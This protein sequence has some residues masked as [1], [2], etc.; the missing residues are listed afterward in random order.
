[1]APYHIRQYQERDHKQ[2]LNVFS[3]GMEEN[4]LTALHHALMLPRTPPDLPWGA[5]C[6]GPSVWFL[7]AGHYEH[8]PSVPITVA[9]CQ[10]ALEEIC[11]YHRGQGMAKALVRTVLQFAWDQGYSDIVLLTTVLVH[12][13]VV[14]REGLGFQ[15]TGRSFSNTIAKLLTL[16]PLVTSRP[17]TTPTRSLQEAVKVNTTGLLDPYQ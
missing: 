7:T 15:K 13:A 14:L 10:T 9:P 11:G 1:M 12:D 17:S 4:I 6:P 5:H 8:L 2:V 3:R 16:F